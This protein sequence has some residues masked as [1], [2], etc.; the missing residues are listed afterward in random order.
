MKI[1]GF[2]EHFGELNDPRQ[3]A[4]VCYPLF[5]VLFLAICATIAGC[6]GWEEIEDFG[7]AHLNWFQSKGLFQKGLPVHDTI[8]RIVARL[9]PTEFQRC[10]S[11]WMQAVH[12]STD[13]E[14][15]A[16]D[17]KVLKRSYDRNSR[18]SAIHMV[19]AFASANG[20]VL[21]QTKTDAKSNEITAIPGL[22][23]LLDIKGCLIS[24]DAI[25]CQTAI[26]TEII[27]G[28]G[29]YLLAV[30]GN[31][32]TLAKAVKERLSTVTTTAAGQLAMERGHGRVEMREYH[33]LPAG[34]L[35][36]QFPQWAQLTSIGVA[37]GYRRELK[38]GKESLE[39]RY[40]ISSAELSEERFAAAVRGHW[41]I[42]NRLHWVLD[43]TMGEDD[44]PIHRG[45]GAEIMACMRHMALNMLRA[46][47]TRKTSIKRK[48]RMAHMKS[49]YL[50]QVLLAGIRTLNK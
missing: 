38:T 27:N 10:F 12:D 13:G 21:G 14:L 35:A 5:D 17:G 28:G 31:Q 41:G 48:Q 3:S 43:A 11:N 23:K 16:I 24:I 18:Q 7:E 22:L 20:V 15:I 9:E 6:E 4:K 47:T 1:N 30:K 44:C 8:A 40:Y 25:G 32:E 19:S 34:E 46:E 37:I 42:E 45:N 36:A 33:V 39:Y 26:A 49:D 50:E 2:L 29:D